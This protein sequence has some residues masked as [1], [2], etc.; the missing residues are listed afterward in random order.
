MK[1][2]FPFG[3]F[4]GASRTEIKT[5]SFA[6]AEVEGFT[7]SE[8]PSHT[9]ENAHFLFVLKGEYEATV[10][11]RKLIC[12]TSDTLYYPGGTTHRD[13]FCTTDGRF[14]TISLHPETNEKWLKDIR[15]LDYSLNFHDREIVWLGKRIYRELCSPDELSPIVLEGMSN[16]LMV[17]TVR[18]LDKSGKPP[19]WLKLAYELIKD[20]CT[21][22][23]TIN[24]I[25]AEVGVHP[26]H[27][28]RTFR[29]FFNCSPGEF[30]RKCRIEFASNML[31]YSKKTL[32][33]IALLSGFSDQ[34]QF[35]RSFKQHTGNTPADF[36]RVNKS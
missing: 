25:A 29:R 9:H 33:E 14:L 8:V 26:L 23:I 35:T 20:C 31:L 21:R 30:L 2:V 13:H 19:A 1:L 11:D 24:E 4:H 12:T 27:L 28:A 16:E 15:F 3:T 36:R 32:V 18:S 5:P 7:D 6:F 22:E 34:S 17:Y 10:K